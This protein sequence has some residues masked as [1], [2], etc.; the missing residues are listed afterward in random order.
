MDDRDTIIIL[1][2]NKTYPR[3]AFKNNAVKIAGLTM[4]Y[5]LVGTR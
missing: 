5:H 1:E 2:E 4:P 3:T